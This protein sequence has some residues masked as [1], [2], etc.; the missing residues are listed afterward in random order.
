L[1][2]TKNLAD[3]KK[4]GQLQIEKIRF[5]RHNDYIERSSMMKNCKKLFWYST[6]CTA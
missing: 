5:D 6:T 2:D 1:P 3:A 4:F